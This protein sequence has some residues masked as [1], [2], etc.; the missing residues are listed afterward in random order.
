MLLLRYTFRLPLSM[1]LP[2]HCCRLRHDACL[3]LPYAIICCRYMIATSC[4]CHAIFMLDA[5]AT[6]LRHA[7]AADDATFMSA[8]TLPYG[9]MVTIRYFDAAR[10]AV[11]LS[12][13]CFITPPHTPLRHAAAA[14]AAAA[15][16][17]Y[18]RSFIISI[19][20]YAIFIYFD[21]MLISFIS[22]SFAYALCDLRHTLR[23][24]FLA[25]RHA[26]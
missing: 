13:R 4:C 18:E 25:F 26:R 19:I 6:L 8:H 17:L 2:R 5:S 23:Y 15:Y 12:A 3:L 22:F 10:I 1:L 20:F 7:A 11:T 24:A 14:Y 21:I 16:F 9:L